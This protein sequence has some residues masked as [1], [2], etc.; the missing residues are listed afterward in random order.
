MIRLGLRWWARLTFPP[1]C[2]KSL[3]MTEEI[4][5]KERGKGRGE[6]GQEKEKDEK[7]EEKEKDEEIILLSVDQK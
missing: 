5:R 3:E 1:I 2:P 7:R 4:Y 6:S